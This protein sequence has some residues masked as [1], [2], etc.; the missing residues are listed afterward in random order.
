MQAASDVMLGWLRTDRRR[1]G[2]A[3]D[4]Y[5]RQLWDGKG[6]AQVDRSWSRPVLTIYAKLCGWT[7]ARPTRDQATR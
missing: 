7:L 2:R 5:V 4:F 6:S 1:R 3:R